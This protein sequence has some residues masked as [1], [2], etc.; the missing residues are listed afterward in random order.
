MSREEEEG[1]VGVLGGVAVIFFMSNLLELVVLTT[2]V[3]LDT[4]V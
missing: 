4:N 3:V 1:E 2:D